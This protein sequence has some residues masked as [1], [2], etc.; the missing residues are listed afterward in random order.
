M[1]TWLS[2]IL[3]RPFWFVVE[4]HIQVRST[5]NY[6]CCHENYI[7]HCKTKTNKK[8]E[9]NHL[10]VHEAL[11]LISKASSQWVGE[12]A[13]EWSRDMAFW[14]VYTQ[15]S[16]CS[17]LV[18]LETPNDVRSVALHSQNKQATSKGCDQ[19]ARLRR[20]IW[21]F[22]GCTYH[23]VGNLMSRLIINEAPLYRSYRKINCISHKTIGYFISDVCYNW[24]NNIKIV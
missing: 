18:S 8:S 19:A 20:Q 21:A 2:F 23:I 17:L 11:V 24:K 13:L 9:E 12:L 16:L 5:K 15:T 3:H 10:P 4:V 6:E 7:H 22:A 1:C 14:Q